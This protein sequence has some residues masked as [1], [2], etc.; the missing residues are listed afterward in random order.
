MAPLPPSKLF[1]FLPHVFR[2]H[3]MGD[4]LYIKILTVGLYT[5]GMDQI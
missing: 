4:D 5:S 3:I 1:I 2:F